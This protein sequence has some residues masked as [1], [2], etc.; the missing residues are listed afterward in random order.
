MNA[1]AS[2]RNGVLTL[3]PFRLSPL[4]PHQEVNQSYKFSPLPLFYDFKK[5]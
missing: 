2:P 3:F 5:E 4:S 1:T